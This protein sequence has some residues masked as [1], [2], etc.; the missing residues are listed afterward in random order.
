MANEEAT[1][2]DG[3]ATSP[4]NMAMAEAKDDASSNGAGEEGATGTH[5]NE[6]MEDEDAEGSDQK[7]HEADKEEV[8]SAKDEEEEEAETKEEEKDVDV[9]QGDADM[10]AD[11]FGEEKAGEEERAQHKDQ[12]AQK[13]ESSEKKEAKNKKQGSTNESKVEAEPALDATT[14][15]KADDDVS[16]MA[17]DSK[18]GKSHRELKLQ[19]S[20]EEAPPRKTRRSIQGDGIQ[21]AARQTRNDADKGP[22]ALLNDQ[23]RQEIERSIETLEKQ[24]VASAAEKR[25]HDAAMMQAELEQKQS[26]LTQACKGDLERRL[27]ELVEQRDF[28]GAAAVQAQIEELTSDMASP[29]K[30]SSPKALAE[31][32]A[33]RNAAQDAQ[34]SWDRSHHALETKIQEL[35]CTSRLK[36]FRMLRYRCFHRTIAPHPNAQAHILRR[37]S[38]SENILQAHAYVPLPM[39]RLNE[40]VRSKPLTTTSSFSHEVH[41]FKTFRNRL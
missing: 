25:Y 4:V 36:T 15:L 23:T 19:N 35:L 6:M 17:R 26:L 20:H 33:A 40:H 8:E 7:K 11:L 14:A 5:D 30:A 21:V 34:E 38:P 12:D 29:T 10:F 31:L 16:K 27:E 13:R 41:K 22:L 3:E 1:L 2:L 9:E 32:E 24:I 28:L 39:H 18:G 37:A